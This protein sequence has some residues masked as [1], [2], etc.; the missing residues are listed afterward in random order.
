M[1]GSSVKGRLFAS[2]VI[3]GAALMATFAAAPASAQTPAAAEPQVVDEIV[4]TGSRIR[5]AETTTEAPVT[6]IDAQSISERGFVSPGQAL[7]EMTAVVPSYPQAD[8]SGASSGSGQQFPNLFGLGPGRTLTLVNGR[9]F[10]TSSQGLGDRVV[11]TNIIPTG[12]IERIDVVQAGGAAVYG[13][14]AIAGVINYVLK[15]NFEGLELDAYYGISSREDYPQG[16]L[17]VTGGK[18][19]LDDRANVAVNLEWSKTDSLLNYDRPISNLGRLTATNPANTG[20]NDGIPA[21]TEVFNAR[22]WEFNYNGLLFTPAPAPRPDFIFSRAGVPQQFSADGQ[23]LIPYDIGT[24]FGVPFASGGEGWDYREISSLRTGV[25]RWSGNVI[26]HVDLTDR[27]RLFGEAMYAEVEGRNP[28]GTYFS[29]TILNGAATGFGAIPISRTNPYLSD[30]VRAALGPGGPPLY[31]SKV[32]G[33]D[34]LPTREVLTNTE[35]YRVLAGVEGDFDIGERNFYWSVSASRGQTEG[36]EEGWGVITAN[37]NK[38]VNAVRDSAGNIVCAVNADADPTNNDAACAPLNPF[39]VGNAS[40]EARNYVT[41]PIGEEFLNTQD[42][43]LATLGG[44]LFDLPAGPAQ[45]SVAFERREESAKFTPSEAEQ[46]GLTGSGVATVAQSASYN[47]NEWSAEVL[48]PVLG[49]DFSL[50]FA[51]SVE[52][53]GAYRWVDHSI[54]GEETVWGAGLKWEVVDGLTF[55]ASKSRNF[56]APTLEQLFA[57]TRVALGSVGQDPCD[58]RYINA[59]PAPSVRQANCQAEWT[60]NGY[61]D[62]TQ[63]QNDSTNFSSANV[64]TGGNR[65]LQNEVSDTVTYGVVFQP[66]FVPGLTIVIDRVE[67][68]LTDGLSAFAPE[69]F[70]ATCYDSTVR[71]DEICATFTRNAQGDVISALN[72]TFNAGQITYRGEV[73]NINYAFPL[74]QFFGDRDLGSIELN[75][76]AT[77]T[78]KLETSVTGFDLTRTDNTVAIPDWSGRFDARYRRGPLRATYT[79]N[80]LSEVLSAQ[81]DTIEQREHWLI[82][83]N[84]RHSLSASYDFGTY[85]LRGGVNNFTDEEP[86][87]PTRT[88]GD[89]IGRYYFMGVTARF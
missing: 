74:G 66:S 59:G 9:R 53:N 65:D 43:Y 68:D 86:S 61:G 2:S 3:G 4:V 79:L 33:D 16:S 29:T 41:T 75:A 26:G 19:F 62:L 70:M 54:A 28:Y 24:R 37:F 6:V 77:H 82:D 36:K 48:V 51:Q 80:Y 5:R 30:S 57:P 87:Y 12:L 42:D 39:G 27:I 69:N 88:H 73:Y 22:F 17:R 38:A 10:V 45:F 85:V 11:D 32:W 46:R 72:T 7:N 25:E 83:A 52:L 76:E 47:T 20:P 23:S 44:E 63:H 55:R 18:N 56:R 21:V 40:F 71:P 81:G 15:D 60:A 31:L 67:V 78:A 35:T 8:G 50:P 1:V 89:I 64:T 58:F 49:G 14:D 34:L 84:I 13:S